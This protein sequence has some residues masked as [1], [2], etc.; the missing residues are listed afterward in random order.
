MR[1]ALRVLIVEDVEDDALLIVR[2]LTRAGHE[3]SYERVDTEAALSAALD[4]GPWDIVVSDFNMPRFTGTAALRVLR[5]RDPDTPLIFVSGTMGEDV[6][7]EAM[8]AGAQA[9]V[10]KRTLA[11][12]VP[13]IEHELRDSAVRRERKRAEDALAHSQ[14]TYRSLVEDSPFG[15]FHR[16]P[17]CQLLAANPALVSMLGYES[18]AALLRTNMATDIYVDPVQRAG[19]VDA[20]RSE[21][22]TSELQSHL[23]L[24][25]R[26]LLE[27][28]N[29]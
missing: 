18:E 23:N 6:A 28:K 1:A 16:T 8:R 26:L 21:E 12:L 22:H 17:D 13:A 10:T 27:N 9:Y 19:L 15:T 2:A 3:P 7:V 25:C 4:R 20:L 11:R 5:A 29:I 24:V 14:A